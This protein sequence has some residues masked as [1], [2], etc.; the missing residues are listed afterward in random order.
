M[1][2]LARGGEVSKASDYA[3]RPQPPAM[4]LDSL[5][6]SVTERGGLCVL[7]KAPLDDATFAT[8]THFATAAEALAIARWIVETFGD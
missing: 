7:I 1:E 3:Q 6:L 2:S 4:K 5:T 8:A